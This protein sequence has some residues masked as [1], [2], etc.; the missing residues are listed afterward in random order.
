[1]HPPKTPSGALHRKRKMAAWPFS[2]LWK[3]SDP[4]LFQ[5]TLIAALLP[6]VLG[7]CGPPPTLSFAVPVDITLTETH[8]KTGTTLKYTCRPGYVRSHSTQTLTC[9][10]DGEWVYNTFCIHKRCRHPGELR[11]GQVEIKTD[12]SFGSQIEFSCSEGFFL[13]GSTTSHCEVQDRGVGWSHPLPQCEI[14]KCKPPPDI[15][16]GRHSGEENFYA[17]G[18]SVTYSC[19][20]RFSLLGHASISCTVENETIGVWRPSPPT[21]EKITCDKPDVSHGEMVSGFGPIYNYKDTIVFKC[22]KGFV[23]RGS[24]VI[25]CDADSKWNPSPP[26]CEPNSCT[27]LPDIPHASWET[28]PR[29]TKEDVYVVGTL[30]RYR[31][32]PGYKPTTDEPM[33][34]IC[35]KNLRWTPYQ[36]CEAL[37]CPE[38]TLNNG[39]ITQHRKSHPANHCVYFYGD[40]ISFSCH[41]TSRFSAICQGDGTWSPRTP[42]CGDICNFHPKIAHGH[43]KQSSSYSFFK[44]EIT[45][46]C[47]KGYILVGQAKLSCSYS[48]WSAP[49][50]QCKALCL[51]PELLNGRLSVDKDQ[52]VEPENVTIQCDS[53]YGVVGPQS[54]TCS[55]NRTWY[56]EVPKCEWET[57]EGCEQVLTGKRLM[58]CLP[59]P[60]DVKMALEVYKL[61]L[62]I[63]QLELQRDSA[64]QYTLD[65]EL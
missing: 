1:M 29:P 44:E 63:E 52:Y 21:C 12:L 6:A 7:N 59:N 13:I 15:R 64:R 24:S 19:D 40:E 31:C 45:Y 58:Q 4:I 8:F 17:Y 43:Y 54:I 37:C 36:G 42:S 16:N 41:E 28:Y 60:E 47:D 14:V 23:L 61:S 35:Q 32:H 39:E 55:E 38:P 26:A 56:P 27:N 65:K 49:A 51:K 46:E 57:P 25:H 10:S 22:Q 33:T 53:G 18:F 2:R 62:E 50:P 9:N 20:H 3:V 30:L 5:M 48:R 11:N 34:V